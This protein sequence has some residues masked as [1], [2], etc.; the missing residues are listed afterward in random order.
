MLKKINKDNAYLIFA[1]F[2]V[3]LFA[4]ITYLTPLAGDDWGYAVGGM[5]GNPFVLAYK[6][7]FNWSGRY[8][9][10]L[11]NYA[12][13]PN[14]MLWN[15]LNPL[16]F[17][18]IYIMIY[19][20][21]SPKI[22]RIL[23]NFVILFLM[24]Y[25]KDQ[26][27]M[28]TY[29]W[30]AGTTYT[31][32]LLFSLVYVYLCKRI[33]IGGD[34]KITYYVIMSFLAFYIGLAMENIAAAMLIIN[35]LILLY[36]YVFKLPKF[37]LLLF[38]AISSI[39]SFLLLRL[40]P[41][42]DYRL[43]NSHPEWLQFNIFEQIQINWANFIKYTFVDNKYLIFVLGIVTITFA[44]RRYEQYKS[45][46]AVATT[47]CCISG[48]AI[49]FSMA[50]FLYSLSGI[51]ALR[52]CFDIYELN[53]ALILTSVVYL[54]FVV[55]IIVLLFSTLVGDECYEGFLYLVI[56]GVS[57]VAMLLS[58]IFGSR[59]SLYTIYYIILLIC[60]LLSLIKT[61]KKYSFVA[62]IT[63]LAMLF[64][65]ARELLFKY[66]LV[67]QIHQKRLE[68]IEYYKDHPEAEEYWFPAMPIFTTHSG[69]FDEDDENH[70]I[71]FL[72][73]YGLDESKEVKFD[74]TYYWDGE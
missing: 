6:Q 44:F 30:I 13:A 17:G 31:I 33:I 42:A 72:R 25:V 38:P 27:R 45:N 47:I 70:R 26:V 59:S 34:R 12:V 20:I 15:V 56:A 69:N 54:S 37:R 11:W 62:T 46:N 5:G 74:Y 24:L 28:E 49:F 16:I 53:F 18:A 10:E 66:Q 50:E 51:S 52:F 23:I 32:P 67:N 63:L 9:A 43:H 2:V 61:E 58:P 64:G 36:A 7:Y 21:I 29:T 41:G 57:N 65:R 22:N 8:F 48:L 71:Y 1:V 19:K 35:A 60:Y 55:A 73:Y 14:K 40:S 68:I 3:A 4:Y 39:A